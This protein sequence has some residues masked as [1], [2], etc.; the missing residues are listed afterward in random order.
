MGND[1]TQAGTDCKP[2]EQAESVNRKP[3]DPARLSYLISVAQYALGSGDMVPIRG[4][5]ALALY[6]ICAGRGEPVELFRIQNDPGDGGGF[7]AMLTPRIHSLR[8]R[9]GF[10]IANRTDR[11]P[12]GNRS[13]YWIVLE[14]SGFPKMRP[15]QL[16]QP[17]TGK[18]RAQASMEVKTPTA[19]KPVESITPCSGTQDGLF[20]DLSITAW[21]DPDLAR[22]AR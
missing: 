4:D 5:E 19:K 18:P 14:S 2:F 15:V 21:R 3:A 12:G 17:K 10:E 22:G 16:A 1:T 9:Y 7:M 11:D 20:G 6:R 8:H 13:W